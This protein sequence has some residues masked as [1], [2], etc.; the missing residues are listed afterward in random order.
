LGD[1]TIIQYIEEAIIA[2]LENKLGTL[3]PV[4]TVTNESPADIK[5]VEGSNQKLSVY[6]YRIEENSHMKNLPREKPDHSHLKRQ[7]LY[8]DLFFMLVPYASNKTD[9]HKI[10]GR[11]MQALHDSSILKST[12]VEV[13][14]T[15]FSTLD[16]EIR[17]TFEPITLDDHTK[18]WGA[19]KDVPYKL[20][21]CYKVTT[22]KIDSELSDAVVR[23]R[24]KEIEYYMG[25]G[26]YQQ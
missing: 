4:P 19:I 22:A 5:K 24:E 25:K 18:I 3:S 21:N 7:S 1:Y 10:L 2:L 23:I 12:D 14:G 26:E 16:E 15:V 13:A 8:L 20:S 17:I 11:A 9:E 6:L